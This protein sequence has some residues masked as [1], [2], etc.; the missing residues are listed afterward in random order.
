MIDADLSGAAI[1]NSNL[2]RV[3]LTGAKLGKASLFGST[4]YRARFKKVEL[5]DTILPDGTVAKSS[6]DFEPF[7]SATIK[8]AI[9]TAGVAS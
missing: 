5:V 3:H 7:L 4:I 8:P 9:S 2:R 6:A 1:I